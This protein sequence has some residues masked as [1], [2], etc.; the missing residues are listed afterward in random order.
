MK[1]SRAICTFSPFLTFTGTPGGIRKLPW[2]TGVVREEAESGV[3]VEDYFG[4][5]LLLAHGI[6]NGTMGKDNPYLKKIYDAMQKN[7]S[8]NALIELIELKKDF[9]D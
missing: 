5:A 8:K 9:L 7:E 2:H 1:I 6:K 4:G 3:C